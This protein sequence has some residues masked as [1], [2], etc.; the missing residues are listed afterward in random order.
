MVAY[1]S[2]TG[3]RPCAAAGVDSFDGSGVSR[4]SA[5]LPPLDLARGQA[6]LEGW[7]AQEG[8]NVISFASRSPG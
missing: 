4:F 5:A 1:A 3:I 7:L 6:D 8:D 2:R